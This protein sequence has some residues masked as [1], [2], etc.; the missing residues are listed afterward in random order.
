MN[1]HGIPLF[2]QVQQILFLS[3]RAQRGLLPRPPANSHFRRTRVSVQ[4]EEHCL[5]V[6][7]FK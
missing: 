4:T 5:P 2:L 3:E 6:Q 1:T 7:C